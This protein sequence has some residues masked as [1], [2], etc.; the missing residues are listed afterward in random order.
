[1]RQERKYYIADDK[2]IKLNLN[3]NTYRLMNSIAKESKSITLEQFNLLNAKE[4]KNCEF[5]RLMN[6]YFKNIK[7]EWTYNYSSYKK[8]DNLDDNLLMY[9]KMG[10]YNLN[11]TYLSNL[12]LVY[13]WGK[14]YYLL[15]GGQYAPKGQLID[16]KTGNILRWV[17]IKNVAP[18]INTNTK[19]IM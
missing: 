10:K 1:M 14:V 18:I 17:H 9:Y 16:I 7:H 5:S 12:K 3:T 8:L 6:I 2:L 13:H 11:D 4:I 19:Q 15:Y